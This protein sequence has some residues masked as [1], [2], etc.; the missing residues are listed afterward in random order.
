MKTIQIKT[1]KMENSYTEYHFFILSKGLN[2]GKPLDMPCPNCFVLLAKSEEERNQ[3]YWL[4]FG[5]W[6]RNFFHP[7]LTGSVIPFIRL[8]DLKAVIN[9]TLSKIDD[10]D[11]NKSIDVM[12]SLQKHQEGIVRQLELIKQAKKALMYKILK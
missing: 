7:F 1:H 12:Q 3:L 4:C 2:S 10:H 5:L 8:E 6:Q 9:E 11:F